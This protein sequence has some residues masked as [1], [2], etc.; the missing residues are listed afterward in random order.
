MGRHSTHQQ[1]DFMKSAFMWF[2]PWLLAAVVGIGA[3]WIAIDAAFGGATESP[4]D[5]QPDRAVGAAES[6]PSANPSP[7]ETPAAEGTPTPAEDGEPKKEKRKKKD[8]GLIGEGVP[9]QIL[10][11]T[12]LQDADDRVAA[13]L[14]PLGFEIV[15][16][17]PWHATP[18]TVVYWSTPE[19]EKT[20]TLLAEEFGWTAQPK[21]EELSTEVSLHIVVGADATTG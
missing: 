4:P 9:I 19:D 7:V 12:S 17:N 21:P 5:Q 11:G 2:L 3:V 13:D 10:N 8:A 15:A 14:E 18:V 6:S 16:M 20:A 1:S